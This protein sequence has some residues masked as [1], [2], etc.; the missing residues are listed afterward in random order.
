MFMYREPKAAK[1]LYFDVI[2]RH[3][4][5]YHQYLD[6][7]QRQDDRQRLSNP[8]WHIH[9]GRPPKIDMPITFASAAHA[10]LRLERGECRNAM[11]LHRPLPAGRYAADASRA[12]SAGGL[13]DPLFPRLRAADEDLPRAE[14]GNKSVP[15]SST[16]VTRSPSS[17]RARAP[18]RSRMWSTKS[19]AASRS[20]TPP[21]RI[22]TRAGRPGG[23]IG[24]YNRL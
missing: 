16:C 14:P 3:V 6:A 18:R 10:G 21:G 1:R 19:V 11:G 7:Y 4:D 24:G 5:E 8:V 12:Q 15:R 17:R 20:S 2:P 23:A 13:R 22:K 9:S